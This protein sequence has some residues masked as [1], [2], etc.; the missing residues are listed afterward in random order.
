[1]DLGKLAVAFTVFAL[2]GGDLRRDELLFIVIDGLV[3]EVLLISM[4]LKSSVIAES[5]LVNFL[6]PSLI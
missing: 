6:F 4:E 2:L 5:D 1:M 3:L